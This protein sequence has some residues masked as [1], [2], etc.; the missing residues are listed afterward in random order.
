MKNLSLMIVFLLL[1]FCLLVLS[2]TKEDIIHQTTLGISSKI[3]MM[4]AIV[5]CCKELLWKRVN[6]K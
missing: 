6:L 3:F 4:I 1:S 2:I 5:I